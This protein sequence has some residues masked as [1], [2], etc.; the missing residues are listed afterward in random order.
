MKT[1]TDLTLPQFRKL[2]LQCKGKRIAIDTE[3]TGLRWWHHRLTTIGFHCP[4]AGI[5]GSIDS[6]D[7][8]VAEKAKNN[9]RTFLEPSVAILHNAKFDLSFL[10]CDPNQTNWNILDTAV[11]IHLW[12]SRIPKKLEIAERM[13]LGTNTKRQHVDDESYPQPERIDPAT[14]KKKKGKPQIW[15]WHPMK[16]QLYCIN[17]A[18]VTYQFAEVLMPMLR[19]FQL[20]KLLRK[21]MVYLK[22]LYTIEHTGILLDPE[23]A[24]KAAMTLTRHLKG[25]EQKLYDSLGKTINW[26]SPKQLSAA[27]WEGLGIPRPINPFADADGVDR[28]KFAMRG[29]Y[30]KTM[31]SSFLLVDKAKHP[32][33]VLI[34]SIREVYKLIKNTSQWLDLMDD[35]CVLH[36]N[37]NATGTRTGRLSSSKPN[38]QNVASTVRSMFSGEGATARSNEYNLRQAFVAR[39]GK[40]ILSIDYKQME[41]R[42][43]GILSQDP[44]MLKFL[45]AGEDVHSQ[46]ALKVWGI[47]DDTHR[48]WSKTIGFGLIYGMTTGALQFRLDMTREEALKVTNDYWKEFPAIRPWLFAVIAECKKN[49]YLRYWSGRVWRETKE[50]D[51]YKGANALIQGG[52]ADLMSIAVIRCARWLKQQ[53]EGYGHIISIVH[54]EILFEV[55]PEDVERANKELSLI[56]QVPDLVGMP[57][58]TDSKWGYSYGSL[59]KQK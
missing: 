36:T 43:F 41:M 8:E 22:E 27:I 16:R 4:D 20:E 54:D 12:D 7:P 50:N 31:T 2:L 32:L 30:N 51:M 42:M 46:I 6:L 11:M 21:E 39:P 13:L 10:D 45:A 26:R 58:Y 18:R 25:L 34:A 33:G 44:F 9:I 55:P 35:N 14:G 59:E 38:L 57:F 52:C 1:Y 29:K 49:K 48:K 5:E 19:E 3:T 24:G 17:D 15:E 23:F 37:F 28:T 53:P 47:A 56:M 40:I